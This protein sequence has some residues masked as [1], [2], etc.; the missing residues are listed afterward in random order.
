MHNLHTKYQPKSTLKSQQAFSQGQQQ[1]KVTTGS[2][3]S[4]SLTFQASAVSSQVE[5]LKGDSV[6]A[7]TGDESM[8]K[9]VTPSEHVLL[10]TEKVCGYFH[11]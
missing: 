8:L 11:A 3:E 7:I 9:N 4:V 1:S 6:E 10:M 2:S 5:T